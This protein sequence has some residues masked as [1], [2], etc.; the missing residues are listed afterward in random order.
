MKSIF[1]LSATAGLLFTVAVGMAKEPELKLI[2][3]SEARNL[4]FQMDSQSRETFIKLM[5][6]EGHIIFNDKVSSGIY[7][8]SLDL[9]ALDDGNYYF[10]TEN[11]IKSFIYTI[12]IDEDDMALLDRKEKAKPVFRQKGDRLFLNLL[13]LDGNEVNIKVIDGS[14]RVVYQESVK[15]EVTIEKAFNFEGAFEDTYT[16][17]V[18][19]DEESY[20]ENVTVIN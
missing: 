17:I 4:V 2:S 16:V 5:D 7:A 6:D 15:N 18:K 11:A 8:K 13:N 14:N 19:D 1:K 3:N 12:G 20:Y 10:S 9:S